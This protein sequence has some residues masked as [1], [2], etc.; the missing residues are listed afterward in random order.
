MSIDRKDIQDL[1]HK[2]E[3]VASDWIV[4]LDS[5]DANQLKKTEIS[6]LPGVSLKDSD[7]NTMVQVEESL[8]D[9]TIR[10]DT[11]GTE[12]M[13]IESGGSVI[14]AANAGSLVTT[15]VTD[16]DGNDVEITTDNATSAK[17]TVYVEEDG[18]DFISRFH[19]IDPASVVK[20][21][22]VGSR[23]SGAGT[24]LD[25][26]V[27]AA[28]SE[29]GFAIGAAFDSSD[30]IGEADLTNA[31]LVFDAN[32]DVRINTQL[33]VGSAIGGRTTPFICSTNLAGSGAYEYTALL[34]NT[35]TSSANSR[36]ILA[37]RFSADNISSGSYFL[38]CHQTESDASGSLTLRYMIDGDGTTSGTFTGQHWVVFAADSNFVNLENNMSNELR[39]GM[40]VES[41]GEIWIRKDVQTT[42]PKVSKCATVNSKKAFGVM[43]SDYA[44]GLDLNYW[45]YY[46]GI[47]NS[48]SKIP[49]DSEVSDKGTYSDSSV[50]FKCRVN[51]TGEGSI[52][53]TNFNGNIENGDYITS[54]EVAGY[55][56]L[57]DD[58]LLHNYTVAKCTETIDWSNVVDIIEHSGYTYKKYLMACTYHCG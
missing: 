46:S 22:R 53:V 33:S 27:D 40:I 47:L 10:F 44:S 45:D 4:L 9:D 5:A 8:N 29:A 54:S 42:I 38:R 55:G 30:I 21:I 34:E 15:S 18:F 35:Q 32:N 16:T 56:Q 13:I 26:G 25:L 48:A 12:R 43:S 51:S 2:V 7:G 23:P 11:A 37:L 17:F 41:T 50:E 28:N 3:V 52:W 39:P 20:G 14:I 19:S 6:G 57:Q 1:S 31:A 36:K 49:E 24:Y 58:D